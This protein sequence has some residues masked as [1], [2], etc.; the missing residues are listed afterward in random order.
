MAN[1][2]ITSANSITQ[3]A[4]TPSIINGDVTNTLFIAAQGFVVQSGTAD[5]IRFTSTDAAADHSIVIDGTVRSTG[6]AAL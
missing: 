1:F 2:L 4:A 6:G 3:T 5:T